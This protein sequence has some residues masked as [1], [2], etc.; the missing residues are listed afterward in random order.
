MS[1]SA[2]ER[3]VPT[4]PPGALG[5]EGQVPPLFLQDKG[6]LFCSQ[7]AQAGNIPSFVAGIESILEATLVKS[8]RLQSRLVVICDLDQ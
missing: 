8:C 5:E 7:P 3:A 1:L 2:K 6:Q 4:I